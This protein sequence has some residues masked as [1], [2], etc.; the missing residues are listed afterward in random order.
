M[1]V[2]ILSQR[3]VPFYLGGTEIATYNIADQLSKRRHEVHIITTSNHELKIIENTSFFIHRVKTIEFPI[4]RNTIYCFKALFLVKKIKPDII[5]S[6]T[7]TING[8]G[9]AAFLIRK[10]L[11][12][13]YVVWGRGSDV[14]SKWLE[15][16]F[17]KTIL[18]N[19]DAAI[20]LT[21]DMKNS[22]QTICDKPVFIISNGIDVDKFNGV[23]KDRIRKKYKIKNDEKVIIFVGRLKPIKGLYYLLSAMKLIQNKDKKIRLLVVGYGEEKTKLEELSKKLS[24]STQVIFTDKISNELIPEYLGAGDIFVLPSLSEGFPVVILEA[25]ASGLPI[26][27]TKIRGIS[28]IVKDGENGFLI[29]PKNSNEIAEK[30]LMLINDSKLI[31]SISDNNKIEAQRYSW[32]TIVEKIEEIYFQV[33]NRGY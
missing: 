22:M 1:K 4:L 3:F 18:M 6:Q 17:R 21:N 14:Y 33:I 8:A 5:H 7:I 29:P 19:S 16:P 2:A 23:N 10:F 30:I 13:P 12:I 32:E 31:K 11:K 20:A 28:E 26:I 24:L 9:F 27:A 25:M 15:K